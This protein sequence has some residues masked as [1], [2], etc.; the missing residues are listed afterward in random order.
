MQTPSQNKPFISIVLPAHNEEKNISVIHQAIQQALYSLSIELEFI[1]VDD[2]SK[3]RTVEEV[4]RL[5]SNHPEVRLIQLTR[6]FGHQPALVAG[7]NAARGDAVITLDSDM[8]HPPSCLP[9]M[10]QTWTQGFQVVQMARISTEGISPLKKAWSWFFYKFINFLSPSRIQPGVADFQLL[11]QLVVKQIIRLRDHKPFI[12]GMIGWFG[13]KSIVLQYVANKRHAGSPTYT[14]RRS[15]ALAG[16]A[17]VLVSRHPLRLGLYLGLFSYLICMI[18]MTFSLVIFLAGIS[19][20]GWTS[21]MVSTLFPAS[22]QL[23]VLGI[24][25]E[26]VGCIFDQSRNLPIY[27]AYPES[28]PPTN[29]VQAINKKVLREELNAQR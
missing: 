24:L 6:Y 4:K 21:L 3:D 18:Y 10:I 19:L 9:D 11:D 15:L 8:Q 25:G 5:Q 26:Y 22:V 20:P 2:G 12:R 17:L 27:V 14:F 23:I 1:F 13:F 16:Q 7:L 29:P 28:Q